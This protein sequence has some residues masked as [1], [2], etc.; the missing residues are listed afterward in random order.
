MLD[1]DK[2]NALSLEVTENYKKLAQ[3]YKELDSQSKQL[4]ELCQARVKELTDCRQ[5]LS[6]RQ[7]PVSQSQTS[8]LDQLIQL[9]KLFGLFG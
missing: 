7:Q 9:F 5:Q 6:T 1:Y 2:L 8:E 4:A 3:D